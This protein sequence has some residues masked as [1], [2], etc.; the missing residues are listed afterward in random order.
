MSTGMWHACGCGCGLWHRVVDGQVQ[1]EH[2]SLAELCSGEG[3]P[4]VR[5][6]NLM[7]RPCLI[8]QGQHIASPDGLRGDLARHKHDILDAMAEGI[9]AMRK[10]VEAELDRRDLG[11][12]NDAS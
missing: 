12:G 4:W 2:P 7:C 10:A 1:C 11:P 8:V 3:V 9:E 5:Q 6:A